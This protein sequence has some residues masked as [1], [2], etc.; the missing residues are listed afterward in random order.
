MDY[1]FWP[2][3]K[4]SKFLGIEDKWPLRLIEIVIIMICIV[5]ALYVIFIIFISTLF[6]AGIILTFIKEKIDY[7]I[8]KKKK[9]KDLYVKKMLDDAKESDVEIAE[10]LLARKSVSDKNSR[11]NMVQQNKY[12]GQ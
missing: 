6:L 5:L 7:R 12:Y 1:L 10:K 11:E 4:I 2:T 9:E 8:E 3:D